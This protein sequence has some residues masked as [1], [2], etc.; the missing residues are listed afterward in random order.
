MSTL[1]L[2]RPVIAIAGS[3]GKTT[4]KEMIASILKT[5]WTIFKSVSNRNNRHATARHI[6]QINRTHRAVVLEFGMSWAGHLRK[7][8]SMIQPNLAVITVVGQSHIGNFGGSLPR[9]IKAKSDLIRY[10]KPTG[11]LFLNADDP[12]T[13]LLLQAANGYRGR[14]YKVSLEGRGDYNASNIRWVQGG[15]RFS[16]ELDGEP[17]SFFIPIYGRHNI[18]NALF[19]IGVT[20]RLGFSTAEIRRGLRHFFRVGGRLN[21]YA[22]KP[23]ARV[24]DDSFNANPNS[25]KAALEVL[26]HIGTGK[27][28][29]VL[30]GMYE[31]G[32]LTRSGHISVGTYLS[33][34]KVDLLFTF[35]DKARLIGEAAV[36]A[37]FD[38]FRVRHYTSRKLMHRDLVKEIGPETTILVKGSNVAHMVLTVNYLRHQRALKLENV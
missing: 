9:L 13:P 25:V 21:I 37:G 31:L 36:R 19:A 5:R 3:S 12:N 33:R 1:I 7:H 24:I 30:G 22:I 34:Q 11:T 17:E 18:Y 14:V 6:R 8:C 10:M 28:I 23:D 32:P 29:A 38:P 15:M 35:G 26:S 4:T 2:N 27:N 20:R 16:V